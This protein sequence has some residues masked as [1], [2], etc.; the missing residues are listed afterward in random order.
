[1][2]ERRTR[3]M[4]T[5]R[6]FLAARKDGVFIPVEIAGEM[7]LPAAI[8][9][10]DG[11]IL[12]AND[13]FHT[14]VHGQTPSTLLR[15]EALHPRLARAFAA[16]SQDLNAR[17]VLARLGEAQDVAAVFSSYAG[18]AAGSRF[19]EIVRIPPFPREATSLAIY[20]VAVVINLWDGQMQRLITVTRGALE[21]PCINCSGPRWIMA[22]R[23]RSRQHCSNDS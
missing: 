7:G 9:N 19:R 12:E 23:H 20:E 3:K 6:E 4:G 5:G 11:E 17:V 22:A 13:R 8:L 18:C 15:S 21:H 10:I 16:I 1:M 14:A 2:S